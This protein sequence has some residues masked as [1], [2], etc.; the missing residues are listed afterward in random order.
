MQRPAITSYC[1]INYT[2]KTQKN[3]CRKQEDGDKTVY[4]LN[5]VSDKLS[6]KTFRLIM[7]PAH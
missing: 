4:W 1:K 6:Y 3:L 5:G 7:Y 2:K